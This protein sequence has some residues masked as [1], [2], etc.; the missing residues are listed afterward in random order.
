MPS[1]LSKPFVLLLLSLPLLFLA[2]FFFYPLLTIFQISLIPKGTLDL[3]GFITLI[4]RPAYRE[5]IAFTFWQALLSTVLTMLAGLPAAYAFARYRFAGKSILRALLTVPFVLPTVVV[6]TAFLALLGP[7]GRLNLWLASLLGLDAP[8]INLQNTLTLILLAHIFYN[9]TVVIRLVGGF[10]ANLDPKLEEAAAVLGAPPW[11]VFR[12]VTFPLLRPAL[13]AAALLIFLFTFT[14]F[15][16]IL[17]LGGPR[18]GTLE[19]EVY[20]QTVNYF[21]LP[22]AAVL[23]LLQIAFTFVLM[24]LYTHLQARATI[25]LDL[26]SPRSV[27]KTSNS[28]RVRLFLLVAVGLPTLFV[29]SPLV[30]L[31][32]RSLTLGDGVSLQYYLLLAENERRT[33]VSHTP[34]F[35][36]RNSLL[37]AGATTLISLLLGILSA[38][39]LVPTN[40]RERRSTW[41]AI[42]D[43]I[44]LLPL[45]TSAVTLGFGFIVALDQP[46]LNLR[47]SIVLIPIAHSLIAFPFVVRS[48]LPVLR[49]LNP[50]LREAAAVLGATSLRLLREIDL[51][52][53]AR[54]ILVGAVFAFAVSM[55]E[56]GATSLIKRPEWPTMPVIIFE[57]LGRPGI[58]NYGRALAMSVILMLVTAVGFILIER[59][60]V[61]D[62]GEF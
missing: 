12:E 33:V 57:F 8:P 25:P 50:A 34:L 44:F 40:R 19:V 3:S 5:V 52:I 13:G 10:W 37:F 60:R 47:T 14:S 30:A 61:D 9:I 6:A 48:I 49:S 11:R 17:I 59:F 32:E 27:E 55:G 28:W 2:L 38:Y 29:L 62:I 26:R 4:E 21:N 20:R 54:P 24:S 22:L 58:S 15:G 43:P 53:L 7:K 16:V 1:R 45:G 46:P 56:F 35:A 39:L 41:R 31:V 18:F 36:V 42:L 51:P 23:S